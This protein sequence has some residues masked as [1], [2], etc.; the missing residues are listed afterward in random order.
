MSMIDLMAQ[1]LERRVLE[2]AAKG[3]IDLTRILSYVPHESVC[4][5]DGCGKPTH[6]RGWCKIHYGR[7]W[8]RENSVSGWRGAPRAQPAP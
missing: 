1:E 3:E 8:Y 4:S 7:W 5:A 2:H 6:A